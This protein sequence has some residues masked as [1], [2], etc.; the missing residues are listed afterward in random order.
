MSAWIT[1]TLGWWQGCHNSLK[2][3]PLSWISPLQIFELF[4]LLGSIFTRAQ[5]YFSLLPSVVTEWASDRR[6]KGNSL[7]ILIFLTYSFS[8]PHINA[9][10]W[11]SDIWAMCGGASS[12]QICANTHETWLVMHSLA[13]QCR[14][15]AKRRQ[16]PYQ[17]E[18]GNSRANLGVD[19]WVRSVDRRR[20]LCL[21]IINSSS[22][23][24][25]ENP[26]TS[27]FD[28]EG[29]LSKTCFS[30]SILFL[31]SWLWPQSKSARVTFPC[32][33]DLRA[34]FVSYERFPPKH[35]RSCSA[36]LTKPWHCQSV[37]ATFKL[38]FKPCLGNVKGAAAIQ[39]VGFPVR[40]V[41]FFF[42]SPS[43][44]YINWLCQIPHITLAMRTFI[45]LF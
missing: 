43:Q 10:H 27:N 14:E 39:Q 17:K 1:N 32:S 3:S 37:N 31:Q 34:A 35:G 26:I 21:A 25:R 6:K 8:S 15:S 40:C 33:R 7:N 4:F 19:F 29:G 11:S 16:E 30:R 2:T 12:F 28:W 22:H 23:N 38:D 24:Y 41:R 13:V 44:P 9:L 45:S 18:T 20:S 36:C 5:P 42:F